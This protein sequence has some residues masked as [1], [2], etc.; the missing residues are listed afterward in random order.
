MRYKILAA[1]TLVA[2]A[3]VLLWSWEALRDPPSHSRT[4]DVALQ[5]PPGLDAAEFRLWVPP[6]VSRIRAIVVLT[7]GSNADGRSDVA[8]ERWQSFASQNGLALVGVHM[9]D[10]P[11]PNPSV[12]DYV[13]ASRGTGAVLESALAELAAQSEHSEVAEAPLLL[14]GFSAGGEF[15]FEFVAWKPE[16]V[17]AFV[18]NKGG[19]Y[20]SRLL[21]A[22]A[23]R[24]PGLFF[25][26]GR[27]LESRTT[28]I[29]DLFGVNREQGALWGLAPE[30]EA[31]HE[32]GHSRE[33]AMIF[34]EDVLRTRLSGSRLAPLE[35]AAGFVGD[36]T[37][38]QYARAGVDPPAVPTAWFPTERVAQAWSALQVPKPPD[39]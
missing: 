22:G 2:A 33:V 39:P 10:R 12:E 4:Y 30:P 19:V 8:D 16:R 17:A 20:Y 26:G 32:V 6:G 34:F 36:L 29:N 14:W 11:H 25:T 38:R 1:A 35:E 18:V 24:V 9:R 23:R 3:T 28:T 15:N 37:T 21:S 31:G 13:D 7:P 5:P 27:D